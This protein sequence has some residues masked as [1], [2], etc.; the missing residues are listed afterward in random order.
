VLRSLKK[1]KEYTDFVG[2]PYYLAP[3]S[4]VGTRYRRT[5][6]ILMSS[7][8]WAIGIITYV[9]MTGRPPFNGRSNSEIFH[10]II[11]K[12]LQFPPKVVLSTPLKNF[13]LKMLK[14]SPKRRMTLQAALEDPWVV[15]TKSSNDMISQD[16]IKVLR[17]FNQ[18]SKLK[19]GI[20]KVLAQNMGNVPKKKLE[21]HFNRLDKDNNG[22]LD[23]Y[24]L[25]F[26]LMD[27]G[28]TEIKAREEAE[29]MIKSI[30]DD[31]SGFI[32]FDEFA[33]IWQRKMLTTNES[34]IHKVFSVFD[35]D[36]D[37][38]I[39]AEEL[40]HVLNMTNDEDAAK[41]TEIIKEV[42]TD[43]DGKIS[44]E[45]FRAAMHERSDF[46]GTGADVGFKFQEKEINEKDYVDID[47]VDE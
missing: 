5:G 39:D 35:A 38:Q 20:T 8:L 43:H 27:M 15:G 47:E 34:Y 41:V 31:N 7:D 29:E 2:T 36:G 40:A 1:N 44:F 11:K 19:K 3:E 45:E 21:E 17:Q 23:K 46:G 28:W 18:Q 13:C 22:A 25:S 12:P 6:E 26:L 4:A 9:L 16:V 14:K 37:G 24:E 32:E 10:S 30:D 42:D 33:A